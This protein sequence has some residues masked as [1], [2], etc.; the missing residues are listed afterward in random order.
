MPFYKICPEAH[1]VTGINV[2]NSAVLADI[3]EAMA[4]DASERFQSAQAMISG[5]KSLKSQ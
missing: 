2:R 4:L 1:I 5:L 3:R